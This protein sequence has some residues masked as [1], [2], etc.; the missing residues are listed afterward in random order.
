MKRGGGGVVILGG[1]H[2]APYSYQNLD[3]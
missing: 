1:R 2:T 3:E